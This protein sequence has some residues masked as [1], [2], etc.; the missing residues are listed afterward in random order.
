MVDIP[1][2]VPV[3]ASIDVSVRI[4]LTN[5]LP[6]GAPHSTHGL[7]VTNPF[8]GIFGYGAA[9]RKMHGRETTEAIEVR[10]HDR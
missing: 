6:S 10:L 2:L 8:A 4:E 9:F 3:D 1:G 5:T 7:S